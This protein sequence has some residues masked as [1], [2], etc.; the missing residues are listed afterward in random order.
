MPLHV[1][2]S[3]I[4]IAVW[5]LSRLASAIFLVLHKLV[6]RNGKLAVIALLRFRKT[7]L[8]VFLNKLFLTFELVTVLTFDL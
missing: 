4:L 7:E 5:A 2:Q 6:A 8:G 1:L 3:D